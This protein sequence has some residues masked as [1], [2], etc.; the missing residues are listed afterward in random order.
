VLVLALPLVPKLLLELE[1]SID[2]TDLD[3]WVDALEIFF[4]VR[5][6]VEFSTLVWRLGLFLPLILLLCDESYPIGGEIGMIS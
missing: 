2:D 1:L 3:F 4:V 5:D 6:N